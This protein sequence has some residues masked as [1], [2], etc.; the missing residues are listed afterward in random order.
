MKL[1]RKPSSL[2]DLKARRLQR[3]TPVS[4]PRAYHSL[5]EFNPDN[6]RFMAPEDR[7]PPKTPQEYHDR[8]MGYSGPIMDDKGLKDGSCNRTACQLPLKGQR[9]WTMPTHGQKG[10]TDGK[11]HYCHECALKFHEADRDFGDPLR[12]TLVTA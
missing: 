10:G 4:T 9:Q 7:S 3:E 8:G 5:R 1:K 11:F 12:C 6:F 2:A